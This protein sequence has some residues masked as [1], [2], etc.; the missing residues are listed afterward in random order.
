MLIVQ[1]ASLNFALFIGLFITLFILHRFR[2]GG[3]FKDSI[4]DS[5]FSA[6]VFVVLLDAFILAAGWAYYSA[7]YFWN[8][9][10]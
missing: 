5:G 8:L 6:V 3:A 9:V 2:Y 7:L 10:L 4:K 1:I